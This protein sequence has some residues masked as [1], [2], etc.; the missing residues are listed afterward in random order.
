[1]FIGGVAFT[2]ELA[3]TPVEHTKGLSGRTGLEPRTGMLFVFETGVALPFWMYG[4]LFP[5]DFIWISQDC[6]VVD[7]TP[8]VP[9]PLPG[10]EPSSLPVY[11]SSEPAAYIFEIY[12]GEADSYGMAVGDPVRF[13]GLPPEAGAA[14]Q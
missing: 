9:A 2:A 1:M 14:C 11:T 8:N 7:I 6:T 10:A 13:S 5:L 12:G 3:I 4:M